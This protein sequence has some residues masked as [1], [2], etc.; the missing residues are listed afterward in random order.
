VQTGPERPDGAR[1]VRT[2]SDHGPVTLTYDAIVAVEGAARPCPSD[3]APLPEAGDV[4]FPLLEWTLPS[5]YCPS[6]ALAPTAA[7][8]FADRPRTRALIPGV[9]AWV[10]ER[11]A[12]VPGAS[13]ALTA[14]DET[15][16]RREGVCRDMAHLAIA[17]LR[18]LDVPARLVAAYAVDLEPPDFHALLEAHDG[19]AWR[20]VDVTDLAPVETAVRIAAGR[21]A[22][23]VA[24]A[25]TNGGLRLANVSVSARLAGAA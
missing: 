2:S 3:D 17:L 11:V 15:L 4:D 12:Y 13:D 18:S 5:R 1:P 10:R 23:D 16:L 24:W 19:E 21:D 8:E 20:L 6:D 25:S 7:A 14:A 22:A 9:A